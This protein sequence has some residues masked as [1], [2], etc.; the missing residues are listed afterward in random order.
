[1]NSAKLDKSLVSDADIATYERDGVVC[2]RNAISEDWL[3]R[4]KPAADW[5]Q[6]NIGPHDTVL[7]P[8]GAGE[9]YGGQFMWL[10]QDDFKDFVLNSPAASIAARLMRS[11]K[12][13]L[14]YDFLLT[15]EP[16]AGNKT[17]WHQDRLYYPVD[18]PGAE[19]ICSIWIALDPV[20]LKSGAVEYVKGSHLPK[21]YYAPASFSGDSRYSDL[22]IEDVPDIDGNLEKYEIVSWDLEPG[23]CVAHHVMVVHGAPENSADI[24]RRGLAMRWCSGEVRFDPRPGTQPVLNKVLKEGPTPHA[25]NERLHGDTFPEFQFGE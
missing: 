20:T 5:V 11:T 17:P 16:G 7:A 15:K 6:K 14:F 13:Q 24:R 1:M 4:L 25:A 23:D 9:F 21:K 3:E 8:E 10:R 18:G 19:R 22:D 2:I 12:V